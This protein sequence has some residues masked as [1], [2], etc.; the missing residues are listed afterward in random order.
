MCE[1]RSSQDLTEL[2]L[3]VCQSSFLAP[4]NRPRF[5]R[6]PKSAPGPPS[7]EQRDS[8]LLQAP[9]QTNAA[10]VTWF[11]GRQK[12]STYLLLTLAITVT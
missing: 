8:R 7:R 11:W 4:R 5:W 1:S 12:E 3:P 6:N 10:I 9:V 2:Q